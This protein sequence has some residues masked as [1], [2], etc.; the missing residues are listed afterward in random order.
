MAKIDLAEVF[1]FDGWENPDDL[2]PWGWDGLEEDFDSDF[3]DSL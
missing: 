2:A 1:G 3:F